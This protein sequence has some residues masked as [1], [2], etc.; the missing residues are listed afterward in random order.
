MS[1]LSLKDISSKDFWGVIHKG[2][3][4]KNTSSNS[5][6]ILGG[7]H[8]GLLFEKCSTR[9]IVSFQVAIASLGGHSVLLSAKE[10]QLSRGEQIRETAM[11]LNGYLDG[12]I[13]R[14]HSDKMLEEFATVVDF[15]V[16]NA[17]SPMYHPCQALADV[18]TMHEEGFNFEKTKVCFV[19]NSN[20]NVAHS[21]IMSAVHT[22]FEVIISS[23]RGYEANKDVVCY[24]RENG[25][26]VTRLED[27]KKAIQQS[28]V[29]YTDV[30]TSMGN[31]G[32]P[33]QKKKELLKYQINESILSETKPKAIIMHC[34][35]MH[36][37]EEITEGIFY[38]PKNRIIQQAH[39]KL[40]STKALLHYLYT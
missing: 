28:D 36:F 1:F 19:G 22:K 16:V 33:E 5:D 29:I 10:S 8:L 25:A 32:E 14:T 2:V 27:I 11:V 35:P 20:S 6:D 15:P 12:L 18:M 13:V 39:N 40:H 31:E 9:T 26:R 17:L 38:S 4:Y 7:K 37:G 21:L 23:P 34:M 30:W 24:A 3:A